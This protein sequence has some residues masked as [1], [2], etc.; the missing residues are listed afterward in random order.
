LDVNRIEYAMKLDDGDFDVEAWLDGARIARAQGMREEDR[1]LLADVRV[2]DDIR[3][4]WPVLHRTLV[5]LLGPRKP[6][7]LRGQ[8]IGEKLLVRVLREADSR[9]IAAHESPRTTKLYDRTS[10]DITL[11]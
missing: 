10:D 1:L 11:E 6:L 8:G 2:S 4:H 9:G 7:Q 3:P 5:S